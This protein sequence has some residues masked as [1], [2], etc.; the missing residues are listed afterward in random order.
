[1]VL[2]AGC[3][4]GTEK[5]IDTSTARPLVE[6]Q[7]R[8]SGA[9]P[10]KSLDC[11]QTKPKVGVTF[12]CHVTVRDG[13]SYEMKIRVDKVGAKRPALTVV[14]TKLLIVG[15]SNVK[16]LVEEQIRET[17]AAPLKSLSCQHVAATVGN[18]FTCK[19]TLVGDHVAVDAFRVLGGTTTATPSFAIK[20]LR[21]E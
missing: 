12:S 20:T 19:L 3:G 8:A 2:V 9:P 14:G 10:L 13:S 6:K 4:T 7:I 16:P 18:T 11:P 21:V 15:P 1:M 5:V 17:G